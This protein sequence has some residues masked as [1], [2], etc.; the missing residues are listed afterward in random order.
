MEVPK[1]AAVA[2]EGKAVTSR[3]TRSREEVK[4]AAC[5]EA[6]IRVPKK[7]GYGELRGEA[8]NALERGAQYRACR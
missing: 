5:Q 7:A 4:V 2:G 6:L 3:R 8:S 1:G